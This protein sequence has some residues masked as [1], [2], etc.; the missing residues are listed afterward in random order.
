MRNIAATLAIAGAGAVDAKAPKSKAGKIVLAFDSERGWTGGDTATTKKIDAAMIA[1]E[2]VFSERQMGVL[3]DMS[4]AV[5]DNEL[6]K[7]TW[8]EK[9][10]VYVCDLHG[11]TLVH[12]TYHVAVKAIRAVLGAPVAEEYRAAIV[13]QFEAI[14]TKNDARATGGIKGYGPKKWIRGMNS[15]IAELILRTGK[16]KGIV[17]QDLMREFLSLAQ[18]AER[19][20]AKAEK[21]IS[22]AA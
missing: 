9:M 21:R 16:G 7:Q 5:L 19:L 12:E 22:K 13:R 14:P 3:A 4:Q 20:R 1:L 11:E 18:Q 8:K 15:T 10:D 17:D 2:G 6:V